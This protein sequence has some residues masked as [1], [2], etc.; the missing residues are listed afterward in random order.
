MPVTLQYGSIQHQDYDKFITRWRMIRD[1]IE[2]KEA[3][4]SRGTT[5]LPQPKGYDDTRYLAYQ[6]RAVLYNATSKTL[7]GY[8]GQLFRKEAETS[9]PEGLE[10]LEGDTDG[11]GNSLVQFSKKVCRD[12]ISQGRYGILVDY[13]QAK[14]VETLEDERKANMK[15]YLIPYPTESIKNW[16]TKRV[17][18]RTIL[19]SLLLESSELDT[20]NGHVF[21][22]VAVRQWRLLEIDNTGKY[23]QRKMRESEQIDS[24]GNKTRVIVEVETI[25]PKLPNGEFLT[26][27]PFVFIGSETFTPKP[28]LPPLYHLAQLNLAHYRNSADF[29][30]AVFMIGQPTPYITGV[31]DQFIEKNQGSLVFG[32]GVAWLLPPDCTV[33][34]IESKSEKNLIFK[35]MD[36]KE[37][38]MVG[39]G[40]KIIQDSTARGSESSESI[41]LRRSGEASQLS[42]IA[43]NV[44]QGIV[45]AMGWVAMWQ[46]VN[47]EKVEYQINKDFYAQRLTHQDI[48]ALVAAW[49]GGAITHEILLDNFRKGEVVSELKTN[50]YIL[51]KLEEEGPT[52]GMLEQKAKADPEVDDDQFGGQSNTEGTE[53]G[54][55]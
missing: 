38:E 32:S 42:C 12:V 19:S 40:A 48:T 44:S 22:S 6:T 11:E 36:A 21:G 35:A 41:Q 30:Q 15:A 49:Q 16:S 17:G 37:Q 53:A 54:E 39:L 43:D 5:Y 55:V 50:D 3:I 34:L 26:E 28:D 7:D 27:I 45:R 13:P 20:G 47:P 9:L 8:L 23:V 31:D 18:A 52:L 24:K 33:G 25:Y 2:G 46:G 1:V 29:E 51:A 10:Y 14:G 4:D